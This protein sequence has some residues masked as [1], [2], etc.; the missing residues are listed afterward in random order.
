[1][2]VVRGVVGKPPSWTPPSPSVAVGVAV[3]VA[4]KSFHQT[5]LYNGKMDG[6]ME[7][8]EGEMGGEERW[9]KQGGELCDG[10]CG[11]KDRTGQRGLMDGRKNRECTG[12][13]G[14]RERE[15]SQGPFAG[16]RPFHGR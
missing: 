12:G 9:R 16:S 4:R 8:K 5:S 14:E 15:R 1:V 2:R 10:G 6:R 13:G 3:G 11:A 7:M